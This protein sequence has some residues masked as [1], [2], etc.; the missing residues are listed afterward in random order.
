VIEGKGYCFFY[1]EKHFVAKS[2]LYYGVG[3]II[4][5]LHDQ[6][7]SDCF[8]GPA[9]FSQSWLVEN[10]SDSSDWLDKGRPYKQ[11]TFILIM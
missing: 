8:G 9:F 11:A 10:F 1:P 6:N 4:I 3:A 7:K 5:C 2:Y